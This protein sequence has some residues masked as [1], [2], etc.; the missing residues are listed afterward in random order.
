MPLSLEEVGAVIAAP[1][2]AGA[3][4][5]ASHEQKHVEDEEQVSGSVATDFLQV[6]SLRRLAVEA[7]TASRGGSGIGRRRRATSALARSP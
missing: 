6:S 2:G 3:D 5:A 1:R 7:T 4:D